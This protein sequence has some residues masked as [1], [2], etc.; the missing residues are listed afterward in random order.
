MAV[1]RASKTP[2]SARLRLAKPVFFVGFMGAGK[3]TVSRRLARMCGVAS[4]DMDSYIERQ[5]G[6]PI[7]QMFEEMG[8]DAFRDTETHVLREIAAMGEPLLVSC[9]GGAAM[10]EQNRRI[11]RETGYVVHLRIDADAA[12]ERIGDTS[13]LPL[14]NDLE[15]ARERCAARMPAYEAAA[16]VTFDVAGRALGDVARDVKQTLVRD[17]VIVRDEG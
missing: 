5:V 11:M 3:T 6:M 16:D 8:E 9:G 17:G 13:S 12:Y 15:A 2:A 4:I 10:R 1:E 7:A 14:F